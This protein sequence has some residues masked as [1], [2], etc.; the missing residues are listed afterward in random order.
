MMN[1]FCEPG[2]KVVYL[3][4]NG[5]DHELAVANTVLSKGETY[6]VKDVDV[7]NYVSYVEFVEVPGQRFNTVQFKDKLKVI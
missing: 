5:H 6:T 2:H 1:I 7:H 4:E 3:A